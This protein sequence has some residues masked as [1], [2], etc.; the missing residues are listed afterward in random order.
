VVAIAWNAQQRLDRIWRRL[1]LQRGKRR[2]VVAVA[3]ARQLAGFCWAIVTYNHEQ[4]PLP[5]DG[6]AQVK[7][8]APATPCRPC[9]VP[10]ASMPAGDE[11]TQAASNP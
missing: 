4:Q 5:A 1:D 9:P 11:L 10:L 6:G 7:P 8:P 3:V 2:T